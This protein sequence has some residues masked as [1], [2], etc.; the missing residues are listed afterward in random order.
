M[1]DT[2][3]IVSAGLAGGGR[4]LGVRADAVTPEILAKSIEDFGSEFKT[5]KDKQTELIAGMDE[6]IK[7]GGEEFAKHIAV[8]ETQAAAIEKTEKLLAEL[9]QKVTA[10]LLEVETV[11]PGTVGEFVIRSKEYKAL[12]LALGDKPPSN[13]SLRV[14]ANTLTGQTPGGD[15]DDT[16]VRKARKVGIVEGAFR[17]LVVRDLLTNVPISSNAWEF[18]RENSWTNNAAETAEAAAKPE[19]D[20][21]FELMTVNI[22]TIAHFIKA[23]VQILADAPA[24]RAYIDRRLSHGVN[25]REDAQLINGDGTGQNL[26]GMT[27]TGNYTAFTPTS[28]DQPID[29]LNKAK[30]QVIG[31]DYMADGYLLNPAD[32]SEIERL[33]TNEGAY[34]VGNPFGSITPIMWGLP[35]AVSNNMIKGSFICADFATSYDYLTRSATTVELGYVNDDFTK[36]LV[37]I[38]GEKRSALAT[39]RPASVRYGP[40]AV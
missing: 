31:D 12:D 2:S 37:T 10:G 5:W 36:N 19:S 3:P 30:Y 4:L 11:A 9:E 35:V 8:F 17:V 27:N 39:N 14:E 28:G 34:L 33:K 23:S 15:S 1:Q 26:D 25:N 38:R 24:L 29:S 13:F 6:A 32:W 22:R 7:A 40:L 16:L 18:T 20:L 21:T